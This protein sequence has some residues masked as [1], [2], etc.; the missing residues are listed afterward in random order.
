MMTSSTPIP[1]KS[2]TSSPSLS[3]PR[4]LL[5]VLLGPT[6]V[7]KTDLS[8]SIAER[9]GIP[10]V[11]ADSRQLYRDIP[12]GTAAPT[13]EQLSCVTHYFV[14]QF[15][16][17]HYYSASLYEQ[18]VMRLLPTLFATSHV[19]LLSGG[20]MMYID[21]VC[22]GID[23]I[24]TVDQETRDHIKQRLATEG[25]D[26]LREEL[27]LIDPSIYATID[28]RNPRRIV[29]A[30]EIYYTSGRPYS[31]FL[32]QKRPER[33]FDILKIGLERPRPELNDRINRR[34]DQMIGEGLIDEARKVYHLRHLNALNTVG[35][36][37]IFRYLSGEW[38]L[39]HA[40][41]KIKKNTRDYAK[42]QMTW[43]RRDVSIHWFHPNQTE[44]IWNLVASRVG[45]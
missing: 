36:K 18:D 6:G 42:K 44:A 13:K 3:T 5:L 41:E 22:N 14:G 37:E 45:L 32:H 38:T 12:I 2:A 30:L 7:G 31:S 23:D 39:E 21:A 15:P 34:V 40:I 9:L 29:H 20:S 17:D 11:N 26:K 24:P 10:I 27:R 35:Y 4:P 1:L 8:L 33:P 28:L 25:L 19:A 43:F 16:L